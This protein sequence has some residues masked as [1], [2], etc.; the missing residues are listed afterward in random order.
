MQDMF[1]ENSTGVIG[2]LH[3]QMRQIS[4]SGSVMA[5]LYVGGNFVTVTRRCVTHQDYSYYFASRMLHLIPQCPRIYNLAFMA[6]RNSVYMERFNEVLLQLNNGGFHEK[7]IRDLNYK[8]A[9]VIR[10]RYGSFHE[11]A[12]KV[13]TMADLQLPYYILGIGF[14]ISF[15]AFVAEWIM[16]CKRC[17][18]SLIRHFAS[19]RS[20][21]VNHTEYIWNKINWLLLI[22][23]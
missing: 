6:R 5:Q 14:T 3:D 22:L 10:F 16:Y 9:W 1:P 17:H 11:D 7:W 4:L 13:L 8:Y 19:T 15:V 18:W 23:I 2:Q 20:L 12:F 21:I